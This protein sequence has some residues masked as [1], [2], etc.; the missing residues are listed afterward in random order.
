M[1]HGPGA[2][3][4]C[5]LAATMTS[6]CGESRGTILTLGNP[7]AWHPAPAT[8]WQIQLSGTVDTTPDVQVFAL[9]LFDT[10]ASIVTSLHQKG[11]KVVCHVSAGS[12]ED[13]RSDAASFP[14]SLS[15][16]RTARTAKG[17]STS[18]PSTCSGP[19]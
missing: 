19:S 7:D 14:A 3:V 5:G 16:T 6:G 11:A 2:I 17:G 12:Y 15:A 18:E 4:L 13:W 1:N 8:S 10:D 9:D